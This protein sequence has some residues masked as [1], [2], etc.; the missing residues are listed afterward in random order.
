MQPGTVTDLAAMHGRRYALL[1]TFRRD[2]TAAPTPVWFALLDDRRFVT[3]TEE[4]TAKVGRIRRD[5]W[6]RV[7]PCDPRG[8]PLGLASRVGPG[9]CGRRKSVGGRRRR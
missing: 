2:G 9:S 4:R 8:K 3:R 7:L 5:P 1:I 6:V